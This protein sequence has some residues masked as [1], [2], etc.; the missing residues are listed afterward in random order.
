VVTCTHLMRRRGRAASVRCRPRSGRFAV[1]LPQH[2]AQSLPA[3]D[4]A[5]RT[6]HF[7]PRLYQPVVESLMVSLLVIMNQEIGLSGLQRSLPEE[8]HAFQALLLD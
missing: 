2:P 3:R 1:V 5:R 4:F 7:F 8:D 6:A